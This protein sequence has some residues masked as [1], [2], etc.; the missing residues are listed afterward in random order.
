MSRITHSRL[1]RARAG[2]IGPVLLILL[3]GAFW[4]SNAGLFN[5]TAQIG[6]LLLLI[7]AIALLVSAIPAALA[8]HWRGAVGRAFAG[9]LLA[10]LAAMLLLGFDLGTWFPVLLVAAGVLLL[11]PSL[12]GQEVA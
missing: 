6:G 7:P 9:L 2:W 4:M 10:G 5:V 12:L 3:G 1:R 8:G 11:V